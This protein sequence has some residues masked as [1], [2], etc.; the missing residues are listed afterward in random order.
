MEKHTDHVALIFAGGVGQRMKNKTKPKQ[1]LELYGKPII[2]YTLEV[3][4]QHP[5][6][7]GIVIACVAGWQEYLEKLIR[8]L[9]DYGK[10]QLLFTA[11]SLEAMKA[12]A[13]HGK[14]IY[15][16]SPSNKI[17]AWKK[18]AHYKPYILYP[19][20]MIGDIDFDVE[21]FDLVEAFS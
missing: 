14:S 20:G 4:E 6:I 19:E 3:Y 5:E 7:D 10:G 15:F 8:F 1:F 13:D 21:T 11:H 12:L 16:L 17:Y 9:N 18:N 2:I